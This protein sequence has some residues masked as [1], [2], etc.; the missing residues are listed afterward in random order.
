M[1]K[2]KPK[3]E[4]LLALAKRLPKVQ[5]EREGRS[6]VDA[7]Y[8]KPQRQEIARALADMLALGEITVP[9]WITVPDELAQQDRSVLV[10]LA[11][12]LDPDNK[13]A[14]RA[15]LHRLLK[16]RK[17][18]LPDP[19]PTTE[20]VWRAMTSGAFG[21]NNRRTDTEGTET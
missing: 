18:H 20:L 12:D 2:R 6:K 3:E 14:E 11:E 5:A 1:A 4:S 13:V 10:S 21:K 15:T 16:A 17:V 9:K 7:D 19:C 8:V